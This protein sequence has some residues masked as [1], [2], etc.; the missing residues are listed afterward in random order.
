MGIKCIRDKSV[1]KNVVC[2]QS[3]PLENSRERI[4]MV[5]LLIDTS[6]NCSILKWKQFF[7]N[8]IL[9]F[10]REGICSAI[11]NGLHVMNLYVFSVLPD[12]WL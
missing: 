2:L 7:K 9:F 12:T 8:F 3:F 4:E 10:F 6:Q 11:L 1:L 5:I